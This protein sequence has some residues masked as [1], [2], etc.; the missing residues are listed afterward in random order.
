MGAARPLKGDDVGAETIKQA[1]DACG[2]AVEA[3]DRQEFGD[4]FLVHVRDAHPDWGYPDV[5]IRNYAD[6]TLRA[7]GGKER[8]DRIGTVEVHRVTP[9]RV[10]D[11]ATFFD[12]DGFADNPAWAACYCSEPHFAAPDLP[13]AEQ[14][15]RRWAENRE[16]MRARLRD[17]SSSGYLAYVDGRPA[18]WVN[19][20]LRS[21]YSL[22]REGAAADP[23]DGQVVGVSCFVI[24]P[25]Y[26]Q[27]GLARALLE[28]VIADAPARGATWVEAYPLRDPGES[29]ARNYRGPRSLYEQM[30]FEA[31]DP[32]DRYTIM[33]RRA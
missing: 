18:G 32:R 9:E 10:E 27:H 24:A 30:G 12:H 5:A 29:T 3:A 33:R 23:A 21:D 11:W 19:A 17:G 6:A 28:R 31:V 16:L 1:C 8:L 7:T 4:R 22:Y 14:E 15:H 20:S 26:R 25:P 13:Q 2:A